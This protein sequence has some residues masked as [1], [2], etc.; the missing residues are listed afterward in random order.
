MKHFFK[1]TIYPAI[2]VPLLVLT[3]S[4]CKGK[5]AQLSASETASIESERQALTK[6][7]DSLGTLLSTIT[8]EANSGNK[9]D[10]NKGVVLGV[11]IA[12][13]DQELPKLVD[14]DKI[15]INEAKISLVIDYPL[16]KEYRFELNSPAGFTRGQLLS[17]ITKHYVQLYKE[18]EE[19]A[20]TKTIPMK[21]RKGLI[22]R[23]ETNG[24]YG[25]WGHDLE[26][27]ILTDVNVYKTREGNIVLALSVES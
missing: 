14:K 26:D 23:N 11:S 27:L 3:L 4:S 18:E 15:V 7:T 10:Y 13:A 2:L 24:K 22:N 12:K 16:R 1:Q 19:S 5:P 6:R 25:I 20:T 8:F 9:Q 21:D 17:E